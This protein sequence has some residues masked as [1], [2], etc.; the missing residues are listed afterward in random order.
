MVKSNVPRV[1]VPDV[2]VT[3][4]LSTTFPSLS[5]SS[6]WN[7]ASNVFAVPVTRSGLETCSNGSG[8]STRIRGVCVLEVGARVVDTVDLGRV[9]GREL[10]RRIDDLSARGVGE[11]S[12]HV[13]RHLGRETDVLLGLGR[14]V[15]QRPGVQRSA[16]R[17][18]RPVDEPARPFR[19]GGSRR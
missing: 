12:A 14:T 6:Y 15:E 17:H 19:H 4:F 13:V 10:G 9:A 5:T 8:D 18:S 11:S 1:P 2:A 16:D 7:V 3:K